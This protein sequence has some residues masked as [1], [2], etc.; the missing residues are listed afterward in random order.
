MLAEVGS[1]TV[2][3]RDLWLFGLPPAVLAVD[4]W[5]RADDAN[6]WASG[7]PFPDPAFEP[8]PA[9]HVRLGRLGKANT[10]VLSD[11]GKIVGDPAIRAMIALGEDVVPLTLRDLREKPS[12]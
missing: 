10:L 12:L 2:V 7:V 8:S 5:V 9:G 6:R 3:D 4:E 11:P 1:A